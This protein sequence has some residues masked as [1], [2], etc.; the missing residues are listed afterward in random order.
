MGAPAASN[1]EAFVSLMRRRVNGGLINYATPRCSV[2][3]RLNYVEESGA[4]GAERPPP[5]GS[6]SSFQLVFTVIVR[7]GGGE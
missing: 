5:P 4:E 2:S 7:A 6:S 3:Y 1:T